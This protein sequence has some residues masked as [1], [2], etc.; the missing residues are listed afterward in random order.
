[1]SIVFSVYTYSTVRCSRMRVFVPPAHGEESRLAAGDSTAHH[2]H[3]RNTSTKP[4]GTAGRDGE[5]LGIPPTTIQIILIW[6]IEARPPATYEHLPAVPYDDRAC[7][8][9]LIGRKESMKI[10]SSDLF[11]FS[12]THPLRLGRMC[13]I[14]L[15]LALLL[16]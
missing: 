6:S 16:P 8:C 14:M 5:R 12:S 3:E 9:P 2:M 11:F 7:P 4:T 1:M 13:P 10:G 15:A